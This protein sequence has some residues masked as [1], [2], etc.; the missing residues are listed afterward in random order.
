MLMMA[1]ISGIGM[2]AMQLVQKV[3][4]D[5]K[6]IVV[7]TSFYP[8]Y[9]ATKNVANHV[10]NVEVVN[11]T[12]NHTGCL[13]EYELTTKDMRKLERADLFLVNGGGM[14]PFLEKVK[15]TYPKLPISYTSQDITLLKKE[16]DKEEPY[17]AH[18]WMD[19]TRY[20]QQ[21]LAIQQA[22]QKIDTIHAKQYRN[23][24]K[25]YNQK[26]QALQE[27]MKEQLQVPLHQKV[28][29]FHDA[30]VYLAKELGLS[31]VQAVD[32]DGETTFSAGEIAQ[33][34]QLVKE[35]KVSVLLIEKQYEKSIAQSVA[36]ESGAKEYQIDSLVTG[37]GSLDSYEKGMRNNIAVLKK[38]FQKEGV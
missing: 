29:L 13:H 19:T 11:L 9:I 35:K 5:E 4:E 14:E 15:K 2:G 22:L 21:V 3:S 34:V 38:A 12:E 23:N 27:E 24:A 36:R 7:V 28:I 31:V 6:S 10:P 26:I 33:L 30:F 20:Q 37:D 8:V 1:F 32:L 17:N 16:G 18:V 25:R